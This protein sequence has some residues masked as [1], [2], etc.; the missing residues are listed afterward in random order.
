MPLETLM[1][2]VKQPVPT[3]FFASPSG[4]CVYVQ[5]GARD[6][7]VEFHGIEGPAIARGVT[8]AEVAE[9]TTVA[10]AALE[11]HR[12]ELLPLFAR[13]AEQQAKS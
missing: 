7:R 13:L 9:A 1:A 4:V 11:R 5:V 3:E 2:S 6:V 12:A 8:A 10:T